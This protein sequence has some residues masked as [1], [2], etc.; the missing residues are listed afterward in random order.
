MKTRSKKRDGGARG[1]TYKVA[2]AIAV[3]VLSVLLFR[4]MTEEDLRIEVIRQGEGRVGL[5]DVAEFTLKF[6]DENEKQLGP[7]KKSTVAMA[8]LTRPIQEAVIEAGIGGV[9]KFVSTYDTYV[10]SGKPSEFPQGRPV[11]GE[12][13]V[14]GIIP[15]EFAVPAYPRKYS[16]GILSMDLTGGGMETL[17]G[18]G[19]QRGEKTADW[20]DARQCRAFSMDGVNH[21]LWE[22]PGGKMGMLVLNL[23]EEKTP[24]EISG[25]NLL[26]TYTGLQV[27][28][29]VY[30]VL[31]VLDANGD[32]E[33]K[34]EELKGLLVWIDGNNDGRIVNE[35][36]QE[37]GGILQSI[38]TRYEEDAKLGRSNPDDGL[39]LVGGKKSGTWE[40]WSRG[41]ADVLSNKP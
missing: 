16:V 30:D 35:E 29:S 4:P 26:C 6:F 8:R 37:A 24:L 25:S 2:L 36:L 38:S 39:T 34:E 1:P 14:L 17:G 18:Q 22:W 32:G 20:I 3:V 31:A 40:F 19:W 9:A 5:D 41:R 28:K 15:G 23:G 21:R 33:I 7:A 13:E 12:I 27:W 11:R 10:P